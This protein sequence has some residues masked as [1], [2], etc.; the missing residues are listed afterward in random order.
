MRTE[1]YH[2]RRGINIT[3]EDVSNTLGVCVQAY[4]NYESGKREMRLSDAKLVADYLN[5]TLDDLYSKLTNS[6]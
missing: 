5:L 6:R 4:R 3:Q 1:L 2:Y